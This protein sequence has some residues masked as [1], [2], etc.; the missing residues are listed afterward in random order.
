MHHIHNYVQY[1]T[2]N[3]LKNEHTDIKIKVENNNKQQE[4]RLKYIKKQNL[5]LIINS[6]CVLQQVKT[7]CGLVQNLP[8]RR[9]YLFHDHSIHLSY[10]S[11]CRMSRFCR[12]IATLYNLT[13]KWYRYTSSSYIHSS[14]LSAKLKMSW[15]TNYHNTSYDSWSGTM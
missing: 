12:N 2:I 14:I 8:W 7:G 11:K 15:S 6:L 5:N 1:T 9:W 3:R 10:D 13:T 4:T